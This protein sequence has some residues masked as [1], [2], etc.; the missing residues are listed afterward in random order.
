L[1]RTIL[2]PGRAARLI[3]TE[4]HDFVVVMLDGTPVGTLDR[5]GAGTFWHSRRDGTKD[6]LPHQIVIDLRQEDAVGEVR[7]LARQDQHHGRIGE[8]RIYTRWVP[9]G[10]L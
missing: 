9:L 1:Y 4:P 8:Y 3:V 10:G 7:Y 2:P 6:P 5:M